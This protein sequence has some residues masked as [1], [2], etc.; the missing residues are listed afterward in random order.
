[1][2]AQLGAPRRATGGERGD[3]CIDLYRD[4]PVR[5]QRVERPQGEPSADAVQH[6]H[7]GEARLAHLRRA[8]K[9]E[10]ARRA[11][12]QRA[13]TVMLGYAQAADTAPEQIALASAMAA[14]MAR[15][16]RIVDKGPCAQMRFVGADPVDQRP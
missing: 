14:E 2:A 16:L 8:D 7:A 13:L 5:G 1:M 10:I 3:R 9:V 12:S 4:R 15:N 11:A 6:A